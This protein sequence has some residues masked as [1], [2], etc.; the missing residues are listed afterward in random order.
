MFLMISIMDLFY[1][2]DS[3]A[4]WISL[5]TSDL[6]QSFSRQCSYRDWIEVFPDF[7]ENIRDT[8][9]W[10]DSWL[11]HSRSFWW[12]WCQGEIDRNDRNNILWWHMNFEPADPCWRYVWTPG[13]F[14]FGPPWKTYS[15]STDNLSETNRRLYRLKFFVADYHSFPP[16]RFGTSTS[17]GHYTVNRL[18]PLFLLWLMIRLPCFVDILFKKPC[19]LARFNLLGWYVL[20][21]WLF[22]LY[23]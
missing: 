1:E 10:S 6:L 11:L 9:S 20:F 22:L 14:W 21:I 12:Q 15:L 3:R 2:T 4:M 16:G 8:A 5:P 19:R 23:H 17:I 7:V 13:V 18:R